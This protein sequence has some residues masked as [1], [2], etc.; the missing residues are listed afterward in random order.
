LIEESLRAWYDANGFPWEDGHLLD[1]K[2][3]NAHRRVKKRKG[4]GLP[5]A[6]WVWY[7]ADDALHDLV[8][9][10]DPGDHRYQD[11]QAYLRSCGVG[12]TRLSSRFVRLYILR[13]KEG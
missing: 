8:N 11:L 6:D 2:S 13:Q 12:L 3:W 4:V 1:R 7:L 10:T 9:Q 5:A